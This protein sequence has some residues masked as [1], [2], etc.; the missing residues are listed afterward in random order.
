MKDG[1]LEQTRDDIGE[2]I[3]RQFGERTENTEVSEAAA[4]VVK[5][6]Y[7][8]VLDNAGGP[9]DINDEARSATERDNIERERIR[10]EEERKHREAIG[11]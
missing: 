7:E 4:P 5:G 6:R 1:I 8:T 10:L 9:Q 11:S 2:Q 3:E